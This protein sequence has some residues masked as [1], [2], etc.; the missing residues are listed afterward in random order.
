MCTRVSHLRGPEATLTRAR[1]KFGFGTNKKEPWLLSRG[2][3][4]NSQLFPPKRSPTRPPDRP[5]LG[6][7]RHGRGAAGPLPQQAPTACAAVPHPRRLPPPHT[8]NQVTVTSTIARLND[9]CAAWCCHLASPRRLATSPTAPPRRRSAAAHYRH[10]R[11]SSRR[12]RLRHCSSSASYLWPHARCVLLRSIGWPSWRA[13][14][15][16]YSC[17][18]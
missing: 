16:A 9:R 1:A 14:P 5:R 13:S 11:A 6:R 18:L 8:R 17:R 15:V 4:S 2:G 12:R 10:R 7:A 3:N